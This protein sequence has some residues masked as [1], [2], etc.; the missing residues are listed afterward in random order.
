MAVY[1]I[2]FR[3]FAPMKH[4]WTLL[5]AAM[6]LTSCKHHD[7]ED[8]P[9]LRRVVVV[10]MVAENSLSSPFASSDLDEM[11][12]GTA[13]IPDDCQLVVYYDNASSQMP[14]I[15]TFDSKQ[16]EQVLYQYRNDPVSTDSAA[17]QQALTIIRQ[18]CPAQTYGLVMWSH[19]S[20]WIPAQPR[21]T[22]GIDNGRN[23]T[24]NDGGEMEISTL[25]NVLQKSGMTWDYV[26][27]DAC[28]MQCVEVAYELRHA[29]AWCIG[30]PAEIPG[31]GAPYTVIMAD[32]FR[33][34]D[35][36]W[37][38]AEDYYK[39]YINDTG[40][41]LSVV[42]T[43]EMEALAEATAPLLTTLPQ[44][45]TTSDVQRYNPANLAWKPAY[46]DMGSAMAK[47]QTEADYQ[48]W[49]QALERAVPYRFATD[50]WLSTMTGRSTY[51]EVT[52]PEHIAA[53]SMYIPV[54]GHAMN[55]YYMQTA[56]WKRMRKVES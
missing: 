11:R 12:R 22:F 34:A 28:F 3:N 20:G 31:N 40:V 44:Y 51:P 39:E 38:I 55:E 26:F 43:S 42:K 14:Q 54:A 10:Y 7:P 46:Y 36:V 48:T 41:V 35:E 52:D 47:W 15:L 6:L 2:F 49:R 19:A 30:S 16:G 32:L 8:E 18:K 1:C 25:A 33:P 56:W 13:S 24:S 9:T 29:T 4:F 45:P 27:F 50:Y 17:M 53:L 23:T 5:L 37:H 21:K